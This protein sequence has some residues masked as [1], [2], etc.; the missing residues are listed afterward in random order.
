M[1]V[2]VGSAPGSEKENTITRRLKGPTAAAKTR[3]MT[4]AASSSSKSATSHKAAVP[5]PASVPASATKAEPTDG[6]TSCD[7]LEMLQ[8]SRLLAAPRESG[9]GGGLTVSGPRDFPIDSAEAAAGMPL[10]C[11]C[12]SRGDTPCRVYSADCVV[13]DIGALPA[14]LYCTGW[15]QAT[16]LLT[17]SW[18]E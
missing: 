12:F 17:Y 18:M 15:F 9:G 5:A 13:R 8:V 6:R 2:D 10:S 4:V 7:A 1:G 3:K 14:I 16:V 11:S